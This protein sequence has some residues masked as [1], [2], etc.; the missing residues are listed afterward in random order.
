MSE[1]KH[2]SAETTAY[3]MSREHKPI[4]ALV[5]DP[6]PGGRK[7]ED[8]TTSFGLRFP[9][10]IL[11]EYLD[12]QEAEAKK[13]AAALNA[14]DDLVKALEMARKF[15][16]SAKWTVQSGEALGQIDAALAAAKRGE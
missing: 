2:W 4:W 7:N 12:G 16:A 5:Y 9:A 15:V 10:L 8:G 11:A 6:T 3:R 1:K 14:H 13:L